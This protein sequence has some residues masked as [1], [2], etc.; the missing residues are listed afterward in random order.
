MADAVALSLCSLSG[1]VGA[2][3]CRLDVQVDSTIVHSKDYAITSAFVVLNTSVMVSKSAALLRVLCFV[4]DGLLA[5]GLLHLRPF[6]G[7]GYALDTSLALYATPPKTTDLALQMTLPGTNPPPLASVPTWLCAQPAVAP[8]TPSFLV[9][10]HRSQTVC[11]WV[12]AGSVGHVESTLPELEVVV[13]EIWAKKECIARAYVTGDIFQRGTVDWPAEVALPTDTKDVTLHLRLFVQEKREP[14]QLFQEIK[15]PIEYIPGPGVLHIHLVAGPTEVRCAIP[16][17]KWTATMALNTKAEVNLHWSPRE[18]QVPLLRVTDAMAFSLVAWILQPTQSSKITVGA[19]TMDLVFI[20]TTTAAIPTPAQLVDAITLP[21]G[22]IHVGLRDV[23]NFKT[24]VQFISIR[25]QAG[26]TAVQSST[27]PVLQSTAHFHETLLLPQPKK[28]NQTPFFLIS[29]LSDSKLLGTTCTPL[30]P[31]IVQGHLATLTLPLALDED[32]LGMLAL[33]VQF[34]PRASANPPTRFLTL[35]IHDI[36]NCP[37]WFQTTVVMCEIEGQT[38]ATCTYDQRFEPEIQLPLPTVLPPDLFLKLQLRQEDTTVAS[39]TLL[40]KELNQPKRWIT[41]GVNQVLVTWGEG[42]REGQCIGKLYV[43][44]IEARFQFPWKNAYVKLALVDTELDTPSEASFKTQVHKLSDVHPSWN[45]TAVLDV[46]AIPTF[47]WCSLHSKASQLTATPFCAQVTRFELDLTEEWIEMK[48]DGRLVGD[49]HVKCSYVPLVHGRLVVQVNRGKGFAPGMIGWKP[50]VR[51]SIHPSYTDSANAVQTQPSPQAIWNECVEFQMTNSKPAVLAPALTVQVWN[52]S[53]KVGECDV[54]LLDVLQTK[55]VAGWHTL[56]RGGCAGFIHLGVEFAETEQSVV[57]IELSPNEKQAKGTQLTAFKKMFYALDKDQSGFIDTGEL[58]QMLETNDQLRVLVNG[59]ETKLL[60]LFDGNNDGKVSFEEYV[61]GMHLFQRESSEKHEMRPKPIDSVDMTTQFQDQIKRLQSEVDAKTKI[62]A[63]LEAER[64][65]TNVTVEADMAAEDGDHATPPEANQSLASREPREPYTKHKEWYTKMSKFEYDASVEGVLAE[66]HALKTQLNQLKQ[67]HKQHEAQHHQQMEH[68]GRIRKQERALLVQKFEG[69]NPESAALLLDIQREG[70]V[71]T[72]KEE[73]KRLRQVNRELMQL[74]LTPAT[75]AREEEAGEGEE[76]EDGKPVKPLG[77][78]SQKAHVDAIRAVQKQ[79][80]AENAML[81][82]ECTHWKDEATT[83]TRLLETQTKRCQELQVRL[84]EATLETQKHLRIKQVESSRR[85]VAAEELKVEVARQAQEAD[86]R[87]QERVQK[88]NASIVLQSKVRARLQQKR[89]QATKL[90][91]HAAAVVVQTRLRG[92]VAKRRLRQLKTEDK[93]AK[94]IQTH[95]RRHYIRQMERDTD[96]AQV[97]AAVMVQSHWRRFVTQRRVARERKKED[98]EVFGGGGEDFA[99][100]PFMKVHDDA[101]DGGVL[102]HDVEDVIKMKTPRT[103]ATNQVKDGSETDMLKDVDNVINTKTPRVEDEWCEAE[104]GDCQANPSVE[105]DEG[106]VVP[107]ENTLVKQ[108]SGGSSPAVAAKLVGGQTGPTEIHHDAILSTNATICEQNE[109]KKGEMS[110]IVPESLVS[111]MSQD[112]SLPTTPSGLEH[113]SNTKSSQGIFARDADMEQTINQTKLQDEFN[114]QDKGNHAESTVNEMN[115]AIPLERTSTSHAIAEMNAGEI[116]QQM[117]QKSLLDEGVAGSRHSE[118]NFGDEANDFAANPFD[119]EMDSQAELNP[120]QDELEF[121]T[122]EKDDLTAHLDRTLVK[123]SSTTSTTNLEETNMSISREIPIVILNNSI[124][125]HRL[126]SSKAGLEVDKSTE[127]IEPPPSTTQKNTSDS[128][129]KLVGELNLTSGSNTGRIDFLDEDSKTS[130]EPMPNLQ[131]KALPVHSVEAKNEVVDSVDVVG[132]E[133]AERN[134]I[135]TTPVNDSSDATMQIVDEWY[136]GG[137]RLDS[138]SGTN[139]ENGM[140]NSTP[141]HAMMHMVTPLANTLVKQKSSENIPAV[142]AKT[143]DNQKLQ[144]EINRDALLSTNPTIFERKESKQEMSALIQVS[145]ASYA[146]SLPSKELGQE[147]TACFNLI[148][149][150]IDIVNPKDEEVAQNM[151]ETECQGDSIVH[152]SANHDVN[153]TNYTMALERT[154]TSHKVSEMDTSENDQQM[155]QTFPSD[156]G[157]AVSGLTELDFGGE[158]SDFAAK[159]FDMEMDTQADLNQDV[160]DTNATNKQ[161]STN[162]LN[163]TQAK[164]PSMTSTTNLEESNMMSTPK[165]MSSVIRN[166]SAH[167]HR[168]PSS[169]AG[170]EVEKFIESIEPPP[171]TAQR[172]TSDGFSKLICELN[173]TSGSNTGRIDFQDDNSKSVIDPI[174]FQE[175]ALA[176]QVSVKHVVQATNKVVESVDVMGFEE[177]GCVVVPTE[178]AGDSSD[179]TNQIVDEW[180]N[181]GSLLNSPSGT[182]KENGTENS[183]TEHVDTLVDQVVSVYPQAP[184]HEE[185]GGC[186]KSGEESVDPVSPALESQLPI[187]IAESPNEGIAYTENSM[188][189]HKEQLSETVQ[190]DGIGVVYAADLDFGAE[191]SADFAANPLDED[192]K[193]EMEPETEKV[194]LNGT[195]TLNNP[196]DSSAHLIDLPGFDSTSRASSKSILEMSDDTKPLQ[197]EKISPNDLCT[198]QSPQSH[199][200]LEFAPVESIATSDSFSNHVCDSIVKVESDIRDRE[201]SGEKSQKAVDAIVYIQGTELPHDTNRPIASTQSLVDGMPITIEATGTEGKTNESIPTENTINAMARNN[202]DVSVDTGHTK[203]ERMKIA[204]DTPLGTDLIT[205]DRDSAEFP[206]ETS[207]QVE[208]NT[209]EVLMNGEKHVIDTRNVESST[210]NISQSGLVADAMIGR[211]AE[212]EMAMKDDFKTTLKDDGA[213]DF[214]DEVPDIAVNRLATIESESLKALEI[215]EDP[216][217]G[218]PNARSTSSLKDS[219]DKM[220][221]DEAKKWSTDG[222]NDKLPLEKYQT[223]NR[224]QEIEIPSLTAELPIEKAEVSCPSESNFD[225]RS[226]VQIFASADITHETQ[227]RIGEQNQEEK[228]AND[229]NRGNRDG[230]IVGS[231]DH[232]DST[233]QSA[234]ENETLKVPVEEDGNGKGNISSKDEEG[235]EGWVV[236]EK[237]ATTSL[238]P[239]IATTD[240]NS[241]EIGGQEMPKT[242]MKEIDESNLESDDKARPAN[243]SKVD[244]AKSSVPQSRDVKCG[245]HSEDEP[246]N[247]DKRGNSDGRIESPFSDEADHRNR[248]SRRT[249]VDH[250]ELGNV[251]EG[252]SQPSA[253][254]PL[255]ETES[256]ER[257]SLRTVVSNEE[258]DSIRGNINQ[259]NNAKEGMSLPSVEDVVETNERSVEEKATWATVDERVVSGHKGALEA[260]A[261]V[262]SDSRKEPFPLVAKENHGSVDPGGSVD[263]A[264]VFKSEKPLMTSS[265]FSNLVGDINLASEPSTARSDGPRDESESDSD[266][267]EEV[268]A[269]LDTAKTS[270]K[271]A[272]TTKEDLRE[273]IQSV[274]K[275]SND[276][277]TTGAVALKVDKVTRDAGENGGNAASEPSGYRPKEQG[278]ENDTALDGERDDAMN[279]VEGKEDNE[280]TQRKMEETVEG[281]NHLHAAETIATKVTPNVDLRNESSTDLIE[282][283]RGVTLARRG[284][285]TRESDDDDDDGKVDD[286]ERTKTKTS[287]GHLATEPSG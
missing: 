58:K 189:E 164:F 35:T 75:M 201:F 136:K 48:T 198:H 238:N 92:L 250:E 166:D 95:M 187:H 268:E 257:V 80:Q 176:P 235:G 270:D 53:V 151:D 124:G 60:D 180:Y 216:V 259:P 266:W 158:N 65:E 252:A 109:S 84:Q 245:H 138:Q 121:S 260:E 45:E 226:T 173:L 132:V 242:R 129:S 192:T 108:Q 199:I 89:Y 230:N 197:A 254:N 137:S 159:P 155:R 15:S 287:E 127:T 165:E 42:I 179:A 162:D 18:K 175:K 253:C 93:A 14:S 119:M 24:T 265:S 190:S 69:V 94:C 20:P 5:E 117:G 283:T 152:D 34:V 17:A 100:N 184:Q 9:M 241:Q 258:T 134:I 222:S 13:F 284:T 7:H 148:Q 183:T 126:P 234:E 28:S 12:E 135:S 97:I 213:L 51:L 145:N 32:K 208:I 262:E 219:M 59:D 39:S 256:Q 33:E 281:E 74:K 57:E 43:Q 218:M 153:G 174:N 11:K 128:F 146:N 104:G 76:M 73:I 142:A 182:N 40:V 91:R 71:V 114:A 21:S 248:T 229:D 47:L 205:D 144:T 6:L 52:N 2:S 98:E 212:I 161:Y 264:P 10:I 240:S 36:K 261:V 22:D 239:S 3:T 276:E 143:V 275:H 223:E 237:T 149:G 61:A 85:Q 81:Q 70:H 44:V 101:S 200:E 31:Y 86:R 105:T 88:T 113:T 232:E 27:Q 19:F 116:D 195:T 167:I 279:R 191:E 157:L 247:D 286:V 99:E 154:Q 185:H 156:E 68:V 255:N 277:K 278:M 170:L 122:A 63:S 215:I 118:L 227:A 67:E 202:D 285:E 112:N 188:E 263:A 163:P 83:A 228:P 171:S 181:G 66:N 177:A 131:E 106:L 82:D 25:I 130:I 150:V 147:Q 8:M 269:V 209:K 193:L 251:S 4:G 280:P 64:P 225:E 206:L 220:G 125:I 271:K 16:T 141:E 1:F 90:E 120:D 178:P 236:P 55:R 30:F 272:G 62:I 196:N 203:V 207:A 217:Q 49:V 123:S 282:A 160:K 194:L 168:I 72:M 103:E 204:D 221:V 110:T 214:G 244:D 140:E 87:T 231:V 267:T 133:E 243:S 224:P 186:I 96:A 46:R 107:L 79:L 211:K 233:L 78:P 111:E 246:T 38:R 102:L 56:E 77:S 23:S 37:N 54:S 26:D 210:L 115:H 273:R 139:R 50:H 41:V 29:V 274:E 172:D 169:E 249:E